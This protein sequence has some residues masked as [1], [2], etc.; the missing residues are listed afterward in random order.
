MMRA[1]FNLPI[2]AVIAL[3][4]VLAGC[5]GTSPA[6]A[7]LTELPDIEEPQ[8]GP[9]EGVEPFLKLVAAASPLGQVLVDSAGMTLY[10]VT[11]DKEGESTCYGDCA[12]AW[13]PLLTEAPPQAGQGVDAALL[14]TAERT[15][16]S[17]QVIYNGMPL[18]YYN[19]D[20]APGDTNGQGVRDVWFVVDPSG[21]PLR[22]AE[23]SIDRGGYEY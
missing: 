14:S 22:S 17:V 1:N 18:Y 6:P 19:Q 15:D 23:R 2:P 10:V 8:A 5:G 21:S 7:P 11:T 3:A 9:E 12:R 20:N 4:A 16:G 13:P